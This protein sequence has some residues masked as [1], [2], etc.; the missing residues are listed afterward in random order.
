M[1]LKTF[2]M[3]S[4]LLI[5]TIGLIHDTV[6]VVSLDTTVVVAGRTEIPLEFHEDQLRLGSFIKVFFVHNVMFIFC[7][8][9]FD[10]ESLHASPY[11]TEGANRVLYVA[12]FFISRPQ[13]YG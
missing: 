6:T 11:G 3:I 8:Y 7:I 10:I 1:D 2:F 12:I 13:I 5:P 4:I 9:S